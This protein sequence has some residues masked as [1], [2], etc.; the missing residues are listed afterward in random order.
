MFRFPFDKH[1]ISAAKK[2]SCVNSA[3]RRESE[4]EESCRGVLASQFASVAPT[5]QAG[6]AS[7]YDIALARPTTPRRFLATLTPQQP[8]QRLLAPFLI[9]AL[10]AGAVWAIN[11]IRTESEPATVAVEEAPLD[12]PLRGCG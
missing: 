4:P 11:P 5:R 6:N 9:L 7:C 1:R 3:D 10:S 2:L 12:Q 8:V